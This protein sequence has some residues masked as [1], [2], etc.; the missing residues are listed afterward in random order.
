M[1]GIRV[2]VDGTVTE[3]ELNDS[4]MY[5]QSKELLG[6]WTSPVNVIQVGD[7]MMIRIWV[8]EQ[9]HL[10]GLRKNE[11]ASRFYPAPSTGV[12]AG[13]PPILGDSIFTLMEMRYVPE[14]DWY[15]VEFNEA[16]L[17]ELA[18]RGVTL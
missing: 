11:K 3:V 8:D 12:P 9:G 17:A 10:K 6:D 5:E 4:S 13:D 7:D 2:N 18:E 15:L 14:P 16:A 1:K